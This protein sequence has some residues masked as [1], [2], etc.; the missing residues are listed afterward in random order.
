MDLLNGYVFRSEGFATM[1][2][3]SDAEVL[4][5][6]EALCPSVNDRCAHRLAVLLQTAHQ[7]HLGSVAHD[8]SDA[9]WIRD[10]LEKSAARV[11][12]WETELERLT[13]AGV[14]LVRADLLGY[15]SILRMIH[16][17]PPFLFVRGALAATDNRAIA[18]VGS[19]S[20]GPEGKRIAYE[21][22]R[23]LVSESITVV[24]GMAEG[25]DTAAHRGA[26]DAGGRTIAVFGTGIAKLYPKSNRDLATE[27]ATSGACVS[28]F[29][30]AQG[31]TRWT[32]PVR[33]IV[34]SGLSVGTV[35]VEAGETSG[36][37]L[38]AH[39]ALRHG[40]RLFMVKH[41]VDHQQWARDL[42]DHPGVIAIAS[43]AEIADIVTRDVFS[44]VE[45]DLVSAM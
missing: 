22:A 35:V 6:T 43:T 2:A 4:A 44:P 5:L 14:H 34:T 32:F 27:I 18:V 40:K 25:I 13:E 39:D 11:A 16:N 28:Q 29:L 23:D 31:P 15:P 10:G 30:P 45:G 12:H 19:R 36:A 9:E 17:A 42:L 24:S 1:T 37:K 8:S 38:Q 7:Q 33:N 21:L 41:L 3:T 26:L 20:A